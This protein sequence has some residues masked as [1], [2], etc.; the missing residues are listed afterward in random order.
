MLFLM[1]THPV[2]LM[3]VMSAMMVTP[4]FVFA[5]YALSGASVKKGAAIA[6]AFLTWGGFMSWVCL[7]EIP[8]SV[9]ALGNFIVPICWAT[10]TLV[11]FA[12]KSWFLD[13]PLSQR[14]L[15]SLQLWRVIGAVFLIEMARGN[16]PSVFAYP[17]GVGDILVAAFAASVLIKYRRAPE[18]PK[19][20]VVAV[21]TCGLVDFAI[22]FFFGFGSSPSPIQIFFPAIPNNT[23]QFPTGL[24]PLF[25][26]PYA[27]FFHALSWLNLRHRVTPVT[28]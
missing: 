6:A 21:I 4:L 15:I 27:I 7:A 5:A 23:L 26:V 11:L 24:I 18:I 8:R 17:A 10:P 19:P 16:I 13:K 9:G 1:Q 25:L 14:L 20:A 3:V 2:T 12:F 28:T 22:A